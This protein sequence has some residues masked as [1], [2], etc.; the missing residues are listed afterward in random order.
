MRRRSRSV[1]VWIVIA[2][3]LSVAPLMAQT[4]QPQPAPPAAAAPATQTQAPPTS[5]PR[6]ELYGYVMTDFGYDIDQI[7][8][9]WFDVMRPTKLPAF[10]Y[11]FGR[12]GR[13][14]T[15]VRQTRNGVKGY[16]PTKYGELKTTF[17]W[18]LFGVGPDAG[19]TTFRLRHAYG[20]LGHFG[21]GQT[22]S[23]FMDPDVF[24]N[25][26]EYWG[27]NGMV[28]F[29]N[30][31][32]RWMPLQGDT[33]MTFA[34]ERSG[35]TQD[36]GLLSD[37]VELQNVRGRFQFP[38]VSGDIKTGGGW[39]YVRAAGIWGNTR[40]DDLQNDQVNLDSTVNRWGVDLTSNIKT[41]G[42]NVIKLAYVFGHGME[43]YMND[44]PVDIAPEPNFADPTK[45]IK[46]KALPFRSLVAFYDLYMG[47]RWSTSFGYS[48][49][50]IAN[51]ALQRPADFK[52]GQYALI[53]LLYYPDENVM[54]GGEVQW[55]RRANFSDGFRVNNY[56][57]QF[58]FRFN[59]S[60]TILKK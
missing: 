32:V 34:L 11:E 21:A 9:D 18:E 12:N 33:S 7:N 23:P 10:K 52:R 16:Q 58:S 30:V 54:V 49:L 14:F 38:D 6:L 44:A 15:G 36:P 26:L 24:P 45:P 47:D 8:P 57:V 56:K 5:E 41:G 19:Q 42:K 20:E 46:A 39:G 60:A 40:I 28:F 51:T 43:N 55:G 53:N 27:P 25:S 2:T 13:T 22:W 3:I 29:R 17:E 4:V 1:I 35:S 31:Q 50:A 37:R 48:Q 59:Y